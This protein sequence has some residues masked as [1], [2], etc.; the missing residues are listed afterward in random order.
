[1]NG[2]VKR[3]YAKTLVLVG[4]YFLDGEITWE[5]LV[6]NTENAL[7]AMRMVSKQ[8]TDR[9]HST[10]DLTLQIPGWSH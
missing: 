5:T 2:D 3:N 9:W 8:E 10:K 4:N 7:G 1:M 6:S